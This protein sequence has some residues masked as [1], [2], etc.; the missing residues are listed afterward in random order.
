[1]R[2]QR[3]RFIGDF[4]VTVALGV[5]AVLVI[6]RTVLTSPPAA[7][8]QRREPVEDV[9]ADKLLTPIADAEIKGNRRASVV[10][11][12]FSDL[13]CPFCDKYSQEVFELIDRNFVATGQLRYAFRHFPLENAHPNAIAAAEA[14]ECAGRQGRFW[15]MRRLLFA[16]RKDLAQRFWRTDAV[17]IGLDATTFA[18][19]LGGSAVAR[20]RADLAEGRRLGLNSTPSFVIGVAQP[21]GSV[22]IATKIRGAQPYEVFE[23]AIKESL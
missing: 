12:D 20:V 9:R 17:S 18:G 11:V 23:K 10:L 19:C 14:A 15:E 8:P 21:D 22:L 6:W 16:K 3:L 4:V 5:A 7:G 2:T 1:M 13:E